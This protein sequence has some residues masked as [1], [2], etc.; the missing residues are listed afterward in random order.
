MLDD[1]LNPRSMITPGAAGGLVMFITNAVVSQFGVAPSYTALV[2]SFLVGLIAFKARKLRLWE[3]CVYYCLN[4]LIIFSVAMGANRAGVITAEKLDAPLEEKARATEAIGA[5]FFSNWTDGVDTERAK[6]TMNVKQLDD[7]TAQE[8]LQ[9]LMVSPIALDKPKIALER[10][11][12]QTR[13]AKDALQ[14]Q[15]AITNA[16]AKASINR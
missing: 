12:S 15:Q 16:T 5:P 9:A 14:I 13:T 11:A 8:A 4:S 1:F 6:I 3:R 2:I 10:I 7:K